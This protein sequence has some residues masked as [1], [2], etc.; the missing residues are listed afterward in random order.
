MVKLIRQ[1]LQAQYQVPAHDILILWNDVELEDKL[2]K[3][4]SNASIELTD[5]DFINAVKRKNFSFKVM[6]GDLYKGRIPIQLKIDGWME[7]YKAIMPL[8]KNQPLPVHGVEATRTK[9]SELPVQYLRAPFR[10]ED[11][12]TLRD[13]PQGSFLQPNMLKERLLV[14]RGNEV[15]VILL[16][17]GIRLVTKGEALASASRNQMVRVKILIGNN[18]IVNA[19]VTNDNEVTLRVK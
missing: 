6:D 1:K 7:V 16:H 2:K 18:K 3:H 12:V 9:I 17:K 14:E 19:Q 5:S 10:I 15:S 4:G 13:I 11:F 8:S